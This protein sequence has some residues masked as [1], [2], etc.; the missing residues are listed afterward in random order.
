[1]V[2]LHYHTPFLKRERATSSVTQIQMLVLQVHNYYRFVVR[3]RGFLNES[4]LPGDPEGGSTE[5]N[6]IKVGPENEDT[7]ESEF[8]KVL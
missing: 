6:D 5:N 8:F 7:R 2:L 4:T 3:E 1:M